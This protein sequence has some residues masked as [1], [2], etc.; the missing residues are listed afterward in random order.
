MTFVG[1]KSDVVHA[2][3]LYE[4][5]VVAWPKAARKDFRSRS[6]LYQQ[7]YSEATFIRSFCFGAIGGV[8][9]S[10][11]KM[12]C[13]SVEEQECTALVVSKGKTAITEYEKKI[14]ETLT[15]KIIKTS[16]VHEDAYKQGYAVGLKQQLHKSLDG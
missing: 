8:M 15:E 9:R 10:I 1:L 6:V 12:K 2:K 16:R 4:M 14:G 3:Q 13:A 11:E 7:L 5:L